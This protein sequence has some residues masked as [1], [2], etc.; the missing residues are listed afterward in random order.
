MLKYALICVAMVVGVSKSDAQVSIKGPSEG[1]TG[2][3]NTL[4]LTVQ[5]KDLKVQVLKNGYICEK[6]WSAL[7][8]LDDKI[9]IQFMTKEAGIYTAIVVVTNQ[10]KSYLALHVLKLGKIDPNI[11]IP[12]VNV[13]TQF[14]QELQ[15]TYEKERNAQFLANL[16]DTIQEVSTKVPAINSYGDLETVLLNTAK[17]KMPSEAA[18]RGC[19]DAIGAYF[20]KK[21]GSDPRKWDA[22]I[23]KD[24]LD[25]I[26]KALTNLK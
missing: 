8:T 7:K 12:P 4:E 18:L 3:L 16:V 11:V 26:L 5:G 19:R 9:I 1:E 13:P 15:L 14:G 25:E 6:G 2:E 22:K 10:D 23:A 20:V 21:T 24:T 17:K